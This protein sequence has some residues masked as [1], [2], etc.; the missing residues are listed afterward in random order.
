MSKL[1]IMGMYEYDNTIFDG[2]VVPSGISKD[3][4]VNE[5]LMQCAELEVLYPSWSIMKRAISIWSNSNQYKWEKLYNTLT[6]EYNPIWNVDANITDTETIS[7]TDN[8]TINRSGTASDNETVNLTDTET[9]NLTDA[10]T[11]N[12]TDT[13]SVKGFNETGWADAE[14]NNKAGTDNI[15]HTGTDTITHTGTDNHAYANNENVTDR[16]VNDTERQYTQRRT[17][18]IGVTTTQQMIEAER[19]VADFN[20]IETV[21]NSFKYRFCIIVY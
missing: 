16:N 13:K 8:R 3:D 7:G 12:M 21:V 14:K 9:R 17:G 1:S 20:F 18:N 15:T 2:L 6:L 4:V 10:E 19:Q 11:V 5:I